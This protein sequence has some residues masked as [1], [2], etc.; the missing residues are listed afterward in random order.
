MSGRSGDSIDVRYVDADE[1]RARTVAATL[2]SVTGRLDVTSVSDTARAPDV[3]TSGSPD[4]LVV[5]CRAANGPALSL[6]EDLSGERTPLVAFTDGVTELADTVLDA[7]VTDCVAAGGQEGVSLLAHRIT[8]AAEH[9]ETVT[10]LRE[11]EARFEA[12]TENTNFAI[13]TIDEDSVVQFASEPVRDLFGYA[14]EELVGEPLTGIMPGRFHDPHHGGI[15][16]YLETGERNLDWGWIE[17]PGQRRDGTEFPLGVSFGE[18]ATDDGRLFTAIIRD[19]SEQREREQR[20]DEMG[21]ALEQST[22]GI[23]ILDDD[24]RFEYVNDAHAAIYGYDDAEAFIGENW[25][26][27][28]GPDQTERFTQTIM[29]TVEAD[30]QWRGEA[31]GVRAD[32]STFPQELSLTRLDDGGFVCIVR[33]ISDRVER[34]QQ[35]QEER[36]FVETIIDTIPDVFYVLNTDGSLERWN[37]QMEDVTGYTTAELESMHALEL[38][39]PEDQTVIAESVESV[40]KHDESQTPRSAVV[41]KQGDRIPH[42]FS[43]K[44]LRDASGDV[45]GIVG[46]GRDITDEQLREQRL[47][48]LSRVLRHNVRNRLSVVV[49]QAQYIENLTDDEQT[50]QSASAVVAAAEA[51]TGTSERARRAETLLRDSPAR[52]QIDLVDCVERGLADA[53]VPSSRLPDVDLPA[54]VPA[55]AT[56]M[57]AIA[58]TELVEN[59]VEHGSTSPASDTEW[60]PDIDVRIE[61]DGNEVNVVVAD[62]GPGLPDHERAVLASG[63][64]TSLEHSTGLGL[65]L[66]KWIVTT[67]GGRTEVRDD[68]GTTVVMKFSAG[69]AGNGP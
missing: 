10:D 16:R 46:I 14:P 39:P 26:L 44:R 61:A 55:I 32:G 6:I 53:E 29:P 21:T 22:D 45:V 7:G 38:V 4:C 25:Q 47:A 68:D 60:E 17:L 35:L 63:T 57:V 67:A 52:K 51:L 59:A 58:V 41:T 62:D 13:V 8:T 15:A 64:E 42:E 69:D 2:E 11:T 20:L 56:E 50:A 1:S 33:D 43:G 48:V 54:S 27:L 28:Y 34:R 31:T 9:S 37:D 66:V 19:I 40:L 3:A 49:G 5:T 23:A 12:L 18:R 36:Q 24:G 30:G 65:W